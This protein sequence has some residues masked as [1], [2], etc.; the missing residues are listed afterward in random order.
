MLT[1][2]DVQ[3]LLTAFKTVFATKEEFQE[4]RNNFSGLQ[5]SIDAYAKK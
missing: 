1:N 4:L 5:V 3:K 2:E